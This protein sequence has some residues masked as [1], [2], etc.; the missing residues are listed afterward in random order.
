MRTGAIALICCLTVGFGASAILGQSLVGEKSADRI[1]GL[2]NGLQNADFGEREA[3]A[4]ELLKIGA[5]ARS[6]IAKGAKGPSLELR[7]R[8]EQLLRK[9]DAAEFDRQIDAFREGRDLD[10]LAMLPCAKEFREVYGS[11]AAARALYC[12]ALNS[13][14]GLLQALADFLRDVRAIKPDVREPERRA[15]IAFMLR[16]VEE[17][18]KEISLTNLEFRAAVPPFDER[19]LGRSGFRA[20]TLAISV[21]VV[22]QKD[23]AEETSL[24]ALVFE[25]FSDS[26]LEAAKKSK[27]LPALRIGAAK[28]LTRFEAKPQSLSI[29]MRLGLAEIALKLGRKALEDYSETQ[30]SDSDNDGRDDLAEAAL[31]A[32]VCGKY[33]DETDID[34]L[35]KLLDEKVVIRTWITEDQDTYTCELR[36]LALAYS[37]HLTAMDP[38]VIGFPHLEESAETIFAL[39]SISFVNEAQREKAHANWRRL[40]GEQRKKTS[41]A[42]P[43]SA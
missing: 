16:P 31:G 24:Q 10:S 7:L 34:R 28:W 27:H 1:Q 42:A 40:K 12:D 43:K 19:R 33:G 23:L 14:G 30:A 39:Y 41:S 29:A 18:L 13:D 26:Q 9:I 3:A 38:K 36:D 22:M 8:C 17:S 2:V 35:A 5:P 15:R 32:I 25:L 11:G 20:E 21:L 37:I 6:Q 4:A